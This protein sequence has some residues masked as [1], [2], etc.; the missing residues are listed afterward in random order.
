MFSGIVEEKTQVKKILK[1]LHGYRLVV[2]CQTVSNDV[3]TGDSI[4]VNGICL[5]VVGVRGESISFDIMEETLRTTNLSEASTED[6]VNL[7]R[8][9]K[10]GD[11]ISG[12]FVTGHIDCIGKV[13]SITAKSNDYTMEIEIP[14]DKSIY[15]VKKGC[16]A[17]DGVGL[18]IAEAKD[19]RL[20]ICLIP[21]TLKET[22]LGLKKTGDK[23]NIEFDIL[24]KYSLRN[25]PSTRSKIDT[26]FLKEHGFL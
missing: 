26:E 13:M 25:S 22:N 7:E 10:V 24:S 2:E 18:T 14:G 6:V 15:L 4:S 16:I 1:N 11:R 8:S 21:F 23:V 3:K 12:H 5:T 9:L 20:K 17:V 19:N